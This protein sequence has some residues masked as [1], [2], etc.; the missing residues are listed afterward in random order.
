MNESIKILIVDDEPIG[1]QLL[2]AILLPEGYDMIFAEDGEKAWNKILEHLPDIILL[3]VMMPMMDGYEV[4]RKI[5]QNQETAHITVFLVTAL[6]DRDSRI[7]G[8]DAG[9]DDYISKPYDR[10]EILAKVKNKSTLIKFRHKEKPVVKNEPLVPKEAVNEFQLLDGL[11]NEILSPPYSANPREMDIYHSETIFKSRCAF[12]KL[13]KDDGNYYIGLSNNILGPDAALAN[14]IVMSF[15]LRNLYRADI[16]PSLLIN[17][18]L[19]EIHNPDTKYK[20]P[21][22]TEAGFSFLVLHV[23]SSQDKVKISGLNQS[24][25]ITSESANLA[26][27]NQN[28]TYQPYYLMGN[29]DLEFKSIREVIY[30]SNNLLEAFSQPDILS[31]L[32]NNLVS[33]SLSALS[34]IIPQ[35]FNQISDILVVKLGFLNS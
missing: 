4:C 1:R 19:E 26:L 11:V 8:I 30:F 13:P 27:T 15:F 21:L 31:F 32:N 9:A 5:R 2:E 20:L 25:F 28:K 6:D 7:K 18:A 35:K 17:S 16:T 3:D 10:I 14:C 22:L 23:N 29:Q 12:V 33:G 34:T 24:I